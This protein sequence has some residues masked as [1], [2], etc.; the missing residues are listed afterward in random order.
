[1]DDALTANTGKEGADIPSREFPTVVAVEKQ[2]LDAVEPRHPRGRLD[3]RVA[4]DK[5]HAVGEAVATQVLDGPANAPVVEIEREHAAPSIVLERQRDVGGAQPALGTDFDHEVGREVTDHQVKNF[6]RL[7][8]NG[9][10]EGRHLW[11]EHPERSEVAAVAGIE[12]AKHVRTEGWRRHY[13]A[14]T[15]RRR[16][17]DGTASSRQRRTSP[18]RSG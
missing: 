2:E 10:P 18:A 7:L 9:V 3:P 16:I 8:V 1:M 5:L 6:P 11:L 12:C 14:R 17:M 15:G 4:V 13:R